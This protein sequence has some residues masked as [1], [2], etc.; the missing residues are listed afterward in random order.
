MHVGVTESVSAIS[1]KVTRQLLGGSTR[2]VALKDEQIMAITR[3]LQNK[4]FIRQVFS[5]SL[6]Y[7]H[8]GIDQPCKQNFRSNTSALVTCPISSIIK[9]EFEEAESLGITACC[10]MDYLTLKL[11][12]SAFCQSYCKR[13]KTVLLIL[14]MP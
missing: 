4:Q 13:Q 11:G 5:K 7:Q 1:H 8:F 9:E 12:D 2:N 14:S 3:L 10:L 6:I